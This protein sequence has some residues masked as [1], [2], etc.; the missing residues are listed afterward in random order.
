LLHPSALPGDL[1]HRR[2]CRTFARGEGRIGAKPGEA[3][4]ELLRETGPETLR[5]VQ[6]AAEGAAIR[7]RNPRLDEEPEARLQ[8]QP[9]LGQF[10]QTQL[11]PEEARNP[12]V[13]HLQGHHDLPQLPAGQPPRDAQEET[14]WS[15]DRLQTHAILQLRGELSVITSEQ[16]GALQP[17]FIRL[18]RRFP[19]DYR[20]DPWRTI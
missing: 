8:G 14:V 9:V 19:S 20:P 17:V 5:L 16:A 3:A 18:A 2:E 13:H 7:H 12:R 11:C 10:Q 6:I 15:L 4:E 1:L